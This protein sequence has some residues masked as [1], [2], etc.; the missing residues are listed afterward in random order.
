MLLQTQATKFENGDETCNFLIKLVLLKYDATKVG[1]NRS[2]VAKNLFKTLT[3][4][5]FPPQYY[6]KTASHGTVSESKTNRRF[7]N[8]HF[9][10]SSF[11][12]KQ[13]RDG[14]REGGRKGGRGGG[15]ERKKEISMREREKM[16]THTT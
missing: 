11:S 7:K 10:T 13:R 2:V 1:Q 16:Y 8:L 15:N 3:R 9:L 6:F 4:P 12:K 14:N 5:I